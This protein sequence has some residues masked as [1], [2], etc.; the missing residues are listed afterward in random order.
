MHKAESCTAELTERVT[1]PVDTRSKQ[2]HSDVAYVRIDIKESRQLAASTSNIQNERL[3][4]QEVRHQLG[5]R[6]A[7]SE[8]RT[9]VTNAGR[10]PK[11]HVWHGQGEGLP[12]PLWLVIDRE[13]AQLGLSPENFHIFAH[14][15]SQPLTE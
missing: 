13:F 9:H 14:L 10:L 4:R 3:G 15:K 2:I 1:A 12:R 8:K 7:N 6:F 5:P 11:L